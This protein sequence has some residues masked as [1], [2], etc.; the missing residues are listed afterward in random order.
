[1]SLKIKEMKKLIITLGLI[2]SVSFAYSQETN[3][4]KNLIIEVPTG[5]VKQSN[6]E[7]RA[8]LANRNSKRIVKSESFSGR[9]YRFNDIIFQIN[10]GK[11]PEDKNHLENVKK[12][13]E[14]LY[15]DIPNANYHS[16]IKNINGNQLLITE[17]QIGGLKYK[18]FEMIN[19]ER[20][21]ITIGTFEYKAGDEAKVKMILA[22]FVTN[23]RFK[24]DN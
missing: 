11:A 6:Q 3:V 23:T 21:K 7:L 13:D 14:R 5:F 22:R 1:L 20:T 15:R 12:G 16:E 18:R 24:K 10:A 9:T 2:L 17:Y 8:F 4:E 19:K